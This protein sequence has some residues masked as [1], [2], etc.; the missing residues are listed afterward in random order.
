MSYKSNRCQ[1]GGFYAS[2]VC[3]DCG[4]QQEQSNKFNNRKN[5]SNNGVT[6]GSC[7]KCGAVGKG[8][9]HA[10]QHGDEYICL[11]CITKPIWD[12][13]EHQLQ[14]INFSCYEEAMY[15]KAKHLYQ[16][17]PKYLREPF[18]AANERIVAIAY[19]RYISKK[20]GRLINHEL[21]NEL[22]VGIR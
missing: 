10:Y 19:D 1:C 11:G 4:L 7:D 14:K 16:D 3:V 21:W 17:E 2:G 6:I 12:G 18:N 22:P 9:L 20:F 13:R 8:R 15:Y 5:Y